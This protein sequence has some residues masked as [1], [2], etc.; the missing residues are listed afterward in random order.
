MSNYKTWYTRQ[1]LYTV[2]DSTLK[3]VIINY[4]VIDTRIQDD[5]VNV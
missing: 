2:M 1:A 3:I 4:K 5:K